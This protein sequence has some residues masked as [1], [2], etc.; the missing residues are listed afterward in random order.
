MNKDRT[1]P[2]AIATED[3]DL[4]GC[5]RCGKKE[6]AVHVAESGCT[7]QYVCK[8]CDGYT[9]VTLDDDTEESDIFFPDASGM[10]ILLRVRP[11][12]LGGQSATAG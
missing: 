4:Y 2:I 10:S 3:F 6:A 5:P 7:K 1:E 9:F 12:P 8:S 11:H